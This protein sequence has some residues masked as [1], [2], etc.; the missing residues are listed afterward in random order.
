MIK[1]GII[2]G[3]GLEY[4]SYLDME[5]VGFSIKTVGFGYNN[6]STYD[7]IVYDFF[8]TK[9]KEKEVQ[10]V[11]IPRHGAKHTIYPHDVPYQEYMRIFKELECSAVLGFTACGS[12][13]G[14]IRPCSAHVID[15]FIDLTSSRKLSYP[16]KVTHTPMGSP[17]DKDI[18]KLI[19]NTHT[20]KT[21]SILDIMPKT[22]VTING[23]RFSTKAE[24]LYYRTI[25][26]DLVNMTT[27]TEC[28]AAALENIPYAAVAFVTDY[29]AWND[30]IPH[31][32]ME[33]VQSR[34]ND[35]K[36]FMKDFLPKFLKA[37]VNKNA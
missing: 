3:S 20:S 1:L 32:T 11:V 6:D 13:K 15:Q 26:G 5:T 12:L 31:V 24:S 36:K 18:T 2:V 22:I 35:F 8:S 34:F 37:Y 30:Q 9:I 4:F 16:E 21:A 14:D 25:G 7:Q 17:F 10:L 33:E 27:A 23:P 19:V 28:I 29:D